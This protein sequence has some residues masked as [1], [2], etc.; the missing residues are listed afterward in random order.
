MV[1]KSIEFT[2]IIKQLKLHPC[3]FDLNNGCPR[4][5]IGR[6]EKTAPKWANEIRLRN[7]KFGEVNILKI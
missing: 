7:G 1:D 5:L 4:E 2:N 6:L 3:Y